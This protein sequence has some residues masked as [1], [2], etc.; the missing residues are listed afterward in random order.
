MLIGIVAFAPLLPT[1]LLG[2]IGVLGP[3]FVLGDSL[4]TASEDLRLSPDPRQPPC[5]AAR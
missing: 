4:D 2:T 1:L 5:V 3:E